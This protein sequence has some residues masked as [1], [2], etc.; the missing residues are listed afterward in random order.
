LKL[1]EADMS[2]NDG[3]GSI[4]TAAG[5]RHSRFET[6][7]RYAIR[8]L[9]ACFSFYVLFE[10]NT[11]ALPPFQERAIFLLFALALC[12][13]RPLPQ[14]DGRG[15]RPFRAVLDSVFA[16][17]GIIATAYIVVDYDGLI[18]R[19]GTPTSLDIVMGA[20]G[21]VMVLE[22][23]RRMIGWSL[24]TVAMIF[25]LYAYYGA[26]LPTY[27]GGHGG[28]SVSRILTQSFLTMEGIFGLALTVMFTYVFP[29]V[30][31]GAVL[32]SVGALGFAIDLGQAV[33]G[34]FR[35][36]PAKVA[37]VSSG[38]L[39]MIN[40]S[41]VANVVTG[42]SVTIPM[43]K[44]IGFQPHVA[45]AV[46]AVASTGGQLIPPVMGAAA[47]IMAELLGVPYLEIA[48]A[49]LI[50]GLLFYVALFTTIHFYSVRH[51]IGGLSA[52]GQGA[53][54]LAILKRP[55]LFLFVL[56]VGCLVGLMLSGY[57][58]PRAASFALI[59]TFVSSMFVKG[60]RL[61]PSRIIHSLETAAYNS[62]SLS[63]ASASVGIII[64]VT[65]MTALGSRFASIIIELSAGNIY[66][67]LV[68]VM[69]SSVILGLGLPTTI[70]YLLLATLAA[71]ALVNL[72]ILP[73]A[74]HMF[75]L[76]F[77]MMSMVTP[78]TALAAYA[79]AAIAGADVMKT[80]FTAWK[81]SLSGYI[82]PFMF[83]LNPA[84]LMIGTATEILLAATTGVIGVMALAAG[85]IGHARSGLAN[86][87]R[88]AV[89]VG[90]FVLIH[91]GWITDL[92]GL[93][94]VLPIV[95]RQ[96]GG[97]RLGLGSH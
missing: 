57:S 48:A 93:A 71:P 91:P 95:A 16:A 86:W 50:P 76:Y 66:A 53:Q 78:P 36:G 32:Q 2:T 65:V 13:L 88:T 89:F 3:V 22:A 46:E 1:K 94:L 70:C 40:G 29:F 73:I 54:V 20:L 49:A 42:G 6:V 77:G 26:Y 97:V 5:E 56:P 96:Y 81:F 72:G 85:V 59:V 14:P 44:R 25:V 55:Q 37:V 68:L 74:A 79:G 90:A 9:A 31:F 75:I 47:F 18:N 35:G 24:P 28:Y 21:T 11:F 41:A 58:P 45:G 30:F 38:L 15:R 10:I 19:M 27:L 84:F 12:F 62:T 52:E 43:M 63:C 39:G 60:S 92:L 4:H 61:T 87:E 64:G 17:L 8:A 33:F 82:L 23:T 7:H 67:A 34:R 51:G 80:G 83:V 69:F